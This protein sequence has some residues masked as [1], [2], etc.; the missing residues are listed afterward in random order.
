M[1]AE[2]L[3]RSFTFFNEV[4]SKLDQRKLVQ[5]DELKVLGDQQL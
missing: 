2:G 4:A 3:V 1:H 5:V